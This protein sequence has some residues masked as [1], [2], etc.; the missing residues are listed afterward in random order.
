MGSG[1]RAGS[2][3]YGRSVG[4][5]EMIDPLVD[6]ASRPLTNFDIVMGFGDL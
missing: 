6:P 1:A 5:M 2:D 3:P 4:G